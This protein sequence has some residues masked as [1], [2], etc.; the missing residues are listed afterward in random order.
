MKPIDFAF[1]LYPVKNLKRSRNFYTKVL[2]FK[3]ESVWLDKKTGHGMIEY[4]FGPNN[5]LTLAIGS[6]VKHFK[7][8]KSGAVAGIE[9][10][11]FAK[12]TKV[13]QRAKVKFAIKAHENPSCHMALFYDLDGNQIMIHKRK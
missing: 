12:A 3:E 13:L 10:E 2:G 1:V 11:D 8:G 7:P 6:G 5:M 4:C 9:V